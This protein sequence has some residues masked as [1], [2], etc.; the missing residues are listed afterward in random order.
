[1]SHPSVLIAGAGPA[2]LVLAIT[3]LKNGVPVRIIDKEPTLRIGS[4]GAGIQP[5]TLELYEFLGVLPEFLKKADTSHPMRRMY[6]LPGGTKVVKELPVAEEAEPTPAT[7]Y[8]NGVVIAQDVHEGVLRA[9]LTAL[10]G[11]V[12]MGTELRGFEQ[13]ADRVEARLVKVGAD[14]AET[15]ETADASWLVGADGVHSVVRKGLGLSFLGETREE[16]HVLVGDIIVEEGL[17]RGFW[18]YWI[19]PSQMMVLRP[20]TKDP[21]GFRFAFTGGP[22]H[23]KQT[24]PSRDEFVEE[25]YKVTDRRDVQFGA[26]TWISGFKP[27]MR[28]VDKFGVGRVFVAGDAAHCHSPT[29][30]Q[31]L[32][33]SVQDAA[34]L[35]WKLALVA[36][37]RAPAALL[38]SYSQERLPVIAEMLKLTSALHEKTVAA[39]AGKGDSDGAFTRGGALGML[40]VN[41][42]GSA[43]VLAEADAEGVVGAYGEAEAEGRARAG[44]RA[45]DAPGLGGGADFAR[46]FGAFG[47]TAHT[48][49]VFGGSPQAEAAVAGALA[50][51]P[52]GSVRVVQVRPAGTAVAGGSV[53]GTWEVVEDREGH[54]YAA[55]AGGLKAEGIR[56]VIVRPDGMVGAVVE[57][58]QG[59]DKYRS[60]IFG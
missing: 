37:G 40:G 26:A 13:Y 45:P 3:L 51:W 4:R 9:H 25:F 28:M 17:D 58:A 52:K 53:N 47:P 8:T 41:T 1:M 30:G 15:L 33:S 49:L 27:S 18:H 39:V 32:N 44:Y 29:G 14:G 31:G 50:R 59:V 24:I 20:G 34:N 38:E 23:W 21:K 5:R 48:A 43:I 57:T 36:S 6:A 55:Y 46:L 10:G 60:L 7:P 54:A 19:P 56:V 16:E 35:G 22:A 42:Q 11:V 12:E 2:G